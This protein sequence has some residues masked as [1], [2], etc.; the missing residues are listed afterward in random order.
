M[1]MNSEVMIRTAT[2]TDKEPIRLFLRK[3]F[4]KDEPMNDSQQLIT[5]E[6]LVNEDLENFVF[7]SYGKGLDLVA[8]Y[9]GKLVGV[10]LNGIIEKG[11][12]PEEFPCTPGNKFENI[13]RL[14]EHVEKTVDY[15]TRYPDI[16]RFIA[17]QI[18]SVDASVRGKGI[19]KKLANRTKEL[20][21]QHNAQLLVIECSS[22]YS[23]AVAKS[24]GFEQ[25]FSMDYADYKKNGKDVI[26]PAPP[27]KSF[28]VY[29]SKL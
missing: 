13:A 7:Q 8:E 28:T 5:E 23:A 11:P 1:S 19:A 12:D 3:F 4:F 16:D 21:R 27:H 26:I 20:G 15:F 10:C 18:L 25:I 29:V 2:E 24:L 22:F 6:N 14:L 17:I 9:E